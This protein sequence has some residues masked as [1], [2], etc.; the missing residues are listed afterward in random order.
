MP[1]LLALAVGATALVPFLSE[2]GLRR[3]RRRQHRP[4]RA[5]RARA[6]RRRRLG[7]PARPRLR[8]LLRLRRLRATRSSPRTS[9]ACTGRPL[10]SVPFVIVLVGAARPPARA[11]L[12]AAARR[13]PRDRD[14][15]LRADLRRPDDERRPDHAALERRADRL[16][17]RA[18]RDH[19]HRP[20]Q[21]PRLRVR[22]D[23]ELPLAL[24]RRLHARG[25][26]ARSSSTTRA[27]AAPGA[28]CARTRSRPS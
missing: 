28:R 23:A 26:R 5:A 21:H 25:R 18:E 6:Q 10:L 12:A 22:L 15:L 2:L 14:A 8:R 7:R 24:A 3:P 17:R 4:L 19:G 1:A 13:L 11:A 27:P 20:D 16:H 9:S